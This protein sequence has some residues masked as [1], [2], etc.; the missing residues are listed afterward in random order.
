MLNNHALLLSM[1]SGAVFCLF[2]NP[3]AVM[4]SNAQSSVNCLSVFANGGC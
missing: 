2:F 1:V 4:S 3:V